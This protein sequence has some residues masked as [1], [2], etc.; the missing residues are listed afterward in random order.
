[1][2]DPNESDK[3]PFMGI[4]AENEND[5]SKE[6][7][8]TRDIL[9]NDV[10]SW[11]AVMAAKRDGRQPL[12]DGTMI[13]DNPRI[14]QTALGSTGQNTHMIG[15]ERYFGISL[16]GD[17]DEQPFSLQAITQ[18]S[19]SQGVEATEVQGTNPLSLRVYGQEYSSGRQTEVVASFGV[20]D[21]STS[22]Y[23]KFTVNG[24]GSV[25]RHFLSEQGVNTGQN[26]RTVEDLNIA[27]AAFAQITQTIV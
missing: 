8:D 21:Y 1:M 13:S 10:N 25:S 7:K 15:I 23:F 24:S 18:G 17:G 19:G 2:A 26:V 16:T 22:R 6:F 5:R 20:S 9:V 3:S 12:N 11:L 27:Q 4:R 14:R